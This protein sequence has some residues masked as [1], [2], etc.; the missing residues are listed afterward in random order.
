MVLPT[1]T[2][3]LSYL[4]NTEQRS[5]CGRSQTVPA[6]RAPELPSGTLSG[7]R[8]DVGNS[9]TRRKR[10][11]GQW[12]GAAGHG[13]AQDSGNS[14]ALGPVVTE[15]R[16]KGPSSGLLGLRAGPNQSRVCAQVDRPFCHKSGNRENPKSTENGG[17]N[18]HRFRRE[19]RPGC[20][21]ASGATYSLP[22]PAPPPRRPRM[23][24]DSG[25]ATG[26]HSQAT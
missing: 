12:A 19:R 14:A 4:T 13:V 24:E 10:Y 11:L 17:S 18:K 25:P 6:R 5:S 7:S 2:V 9:P 21:A 20:R 16:D 23:N 22:T 26:G 1:A 15:L 3:F 8:G